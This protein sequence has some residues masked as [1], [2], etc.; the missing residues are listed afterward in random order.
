MKKVITILMISSLL[1][2][3]IGFN[4]YHHLCHHTG[5]IQ[6]ALVK[7][8]FLCDHTNHHHS[9]EMCPHCKVDDTKLLNKVLFEESECCE[10]FTDHIALDLDYV[11]AEHNISTQY[12]ITHT[13]DYTQPISFSNPSQEIDFSSIGPPEFELIPDR[14]IEFI[15]YSSLSDYYCS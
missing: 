3:T 8:D 2:S 6:T 9:H 13:V 7:A 10:D 12:I 1:I 4:I 11:K 14:I 15:H 5:K